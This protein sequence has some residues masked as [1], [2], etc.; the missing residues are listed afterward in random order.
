M[1]AF[2]SVAID[3][4]QVEVGVTSAGVAEHHRYPT[5]LSHT[6]PPTGSGAT[7]EAVPQFGGNSTSTTIAYPGGIGKVPTPSEIVE[8][9]DQY[10]IGQALAKRVLAVATHNHYKRVHQ[11]TRPQHDPASSTPQ[12]QQQ[13]QPTHSQQNLHH[14]QHLPTVQPPHPPQP[15]AVQAGQPLAHAAHLNT[16]IAEGALSGA[17]PSSKA[18]SHAIGIH[19]SSPSPST[20]PSH[21]P[22][23]LDPA[24]PA[25]PHPLG[26]PLPKDQ[27]L[28]ASGSAYEDDPLGVELDKSNVI[29]LGPTGS[30]KTLLA[31]TLARLVNVPFAMADATT[32]TQAG[33]VGDDVES[34][35]HKLLQACNFQVEVAQQGIVFID[36][37][38]KIAK[39]SSEGF[40][41]TRDVSGE[42]V[43][44]ALL[45]MLEGT[46]V[47][48]PEKGGR[49]N[50]RGDFIQ[51]DTR[52]ILFICGGAFV[53]LSRQVL[54]SRHE[55]SIG[56]GNKVRARAL[57][58]WAVRNGS[59]PGPDSQI[60]QRVEHHDLIQYGLIPEFV[61]RLPV[62]VSTQ[63]LSEAEL[64]QVLTEP[65]N[66]LSR[67][68]SSLL[69]MSGA[70]FRVTRLA[71]KAI[72]RQALNKG[73]GTRGLRS[74]MEHLLMDAMYQV[75]DLVEGRGEVHVANSQPPP[76]PQQQQQRQQQQSGSSPFVVVLLDE[77]SVVQ[78]SGAKLL[79][80]EAAD[81][82]CLQEMQEQEEEQQVAAEVR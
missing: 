26:A 17:I 52:D 53:D 42:G 29:M 41:I 34:I 3:P 11:R 15:V 23:P 60:L 51:V 76:S 12:Q 39:R 18:A 61:G 80:V 19:A 10:V 81:Q 25:P 30:G 7:L 21:T 28:A 33:Y 48:V 68:Y 75:P 9:L 55:S 45:K 5:A 63:E 6:S 1:Q 38:D 32:L 40:T 69:A 4:Q 70:Q 73:T 8:A 44:Q 50:P 2:H 74:I 57:P 27:P 14:P 54:D 72:A 62:I 16:R 56:F 58:A 49:K 35:L 47:N 78:G 79:S 59:G 64:V 46:V 22:M 36:E 20:L 24:T 13:Q 43:Q 71:L 77:E 82:I 66:A 37:I 67:Q 65:R 31:K